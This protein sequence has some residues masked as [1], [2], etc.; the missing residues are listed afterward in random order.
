MI[1]DEKDLV[2]K[3]AKD[4]NA[5]INKGL[6]YYTP[7]IQRADIEFFMSRNRI[8]RPE[9]EFL[10]NKIERQILDRDKELLS[11]M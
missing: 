7:D 5:I 1:T 2:S 4:K 10:L 6:D 8:T 3:P 11:R 9:G